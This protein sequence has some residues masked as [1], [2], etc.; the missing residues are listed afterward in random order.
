MHLETDID[1]ELLRFYKHKAPSHFRQD[2]TIKLTA[3]QRRTIAAVLYHTCTKTYPELRIH[4]AAMHISIRTMQFGVRFLQDPSGK[5]KVMLRR[6]EDL[7]LGYPLLS[8]MIPSDNLTFTFDPLNLLH[9]QWRNPWNR[10]LT[11]TDSFFDLMENAQIE[12]HSVLKKLSHTFSCQ[13][14]S[15]KEHRQTKALLKQLGNL[16]YHSGLDIT[17]KH[18]FYS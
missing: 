9:K 16:S 15:A 2:S 5:K 3:A 12:Y 6:F 4:R 14:Y 13:P 8:A 10:T 11:S 7:T 18:S 17:K 1:T